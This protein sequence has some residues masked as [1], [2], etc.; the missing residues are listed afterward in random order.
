MDVNEDNKGI[1]MYGVPE[2]LDFME[3]VLLKQE[4]QEEFRE[5]LW[6]IVIDA[7]QY[8]PQKNS[9]VQNISSF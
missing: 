8:L 2:M 6:D 7:S 1:I 3:E 5:S 9:K 4:R